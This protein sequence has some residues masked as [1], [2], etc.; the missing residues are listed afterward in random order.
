MNRRSAIRA[1]LAACVLSLLLSGRP[2]TRADEAASP[3]TS[4]T[5]TVLGKSHERF[6]LN[7][8]P[9]FLVGISYYGG[10]GAPEET[11]RR[12]LDDLRRL[13][14]NWLRV[15][16]TWD[17]FGEN[18]SA[19]DA[20]G[21]GREPFL[22]RLKTLVD[23]CDRR[24]MAVDVTLARSNP[25][26]RTCDSVHIPNLAAHQQAIRTIVAALTPHRNWYLDLANERDVG[27]ERFVPI[28]ELRQL[29]QLAPN[30]TRRCW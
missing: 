25:A 29:R 19:L 10:L 23:E 6:T 4:K 16:A 21:N 8:R 5:G 17:S 1:I 12:D 7:G 30:S 18:T 13:G 9:E 11:V 15:W 2:Q 26:K 24:G 28:H 3:A 14:F 27:D 20:A 22:A